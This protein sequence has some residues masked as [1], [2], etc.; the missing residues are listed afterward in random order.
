MNDHFL[1]WANALLDNRLLAPLDDVELSLAKRVGV[2][3][4]SA[5]CGPALDDSLRTLAHTLR[6]LIG[7]RLSAKYASAAILVRARTFLGEQCLDR[8]S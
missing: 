8:R 5:R 7:R 6:G 1:D 3:S 2:A 4:D